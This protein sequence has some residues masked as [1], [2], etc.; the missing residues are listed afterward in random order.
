MVNLRQPRDVAQILLSV[1][2]LAIMIIACLW[3]VRPF[4]LGFAWAA[5][6]VVAT[7]PLLLRLQKLLF[8]RRGLAVLV[9]TL[10][11]FLLFIIPI[12]LLV[13]SLVDSSGPVIRAV[14]S[15]DMTLPDLAWL[16]SIPVV[17]AKLYSGWHSLLEMGGSAL[18]AKVRPYIGTTTTW[19]VG[20]A[21]H[22]GRF[23][24]HCTLMLVFSALLYWRGEQVA[25][26][27]RHFATRLAGKRGDAAVLLA[28]Q[29]VR[30][31]ALGVVVTALVQAVLGGIGLAISGVPYATIFTVV[32]LMTCLAQLGP[33]LVLVPCIIWLYWTGD[34][35]WGTVLL[36]WSCVVGTMDNVIRPL[37]IRMGADLPL[38]LI[39]SGV[40]GGLIA[41]GMI[42]LFIGPVL[43][44]VTWRLFSAW[45]H[46]VPAPGTDPDVI[47]SELE[48][49]E[50]KNAQ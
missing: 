43:L 27:V 25:L 42:G 33:L 37:L 21:A 20:Q 35:T 15:G 13:N 44:A 14:T 28:A 6:V 5:T 36:V 10:L 17:G 24:M 45:V 22:I 9:M 4:V 26:G 12:A 38:I 31:V 39:L 2:F 34:T 47:L 29:A 19:F 41:F 1:L 11:L 18:M 8:G 48:E 16:N 32:M 50:D 40:I 7:W 49:L 23:M 46:E 3:I 30:A